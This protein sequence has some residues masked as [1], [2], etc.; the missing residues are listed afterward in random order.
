MSQTTKVLLT[1][2]AVVVVLGG[3]YYF[4]ARTRTGSVSDEQQVGMMVPQETVGTSSE[5]AVLP[6]GNDTSDAALGQDLSAIDS[7][8]SGL[9]AD[10]ASV[11]QSLNDQQ[12]TQ[13]SL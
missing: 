9:N 1:V 13:S 11:N 3:I 10:N 6:T 2:V 12:V 4:Y 7:Q 8:I 5:A